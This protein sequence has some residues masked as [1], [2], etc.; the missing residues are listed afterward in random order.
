[1]RIGISLGGIPAGDDVFERIK[2][3]GFEC[4]DYDTIANTAKHPA[5][6]LNDAELKKL[7][8]RVEQ[9]KIHMS[10]F[11]NIK[12]I[13]IWVSAAEDVL[14]NEYR[15]SIRSKGIAINGVAAKYGGGGHDQAS[16]AK[17]SSIEELDSLIKDLDE[18]IK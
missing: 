11:S 14:N 17:L 9:A 3:S 18:L 6:A 10:L 5:Y 7:G 2:A 12:G 4:I 13:E 8:I 16:G 1:M 15:V